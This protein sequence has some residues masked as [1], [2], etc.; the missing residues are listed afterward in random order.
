VYLGS[1]RLRTEDGIEVWP[2]QYLLKAL[3]EKRLWP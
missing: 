1:R 2:L 3:A